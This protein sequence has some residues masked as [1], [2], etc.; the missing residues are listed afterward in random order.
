MH[1]S[2][3]V[4]EGLGAGR[5]DL[6]GALDTGGSAGVRAARARPRERVTELPQRAFRPPRANSGRA[7]AL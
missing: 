7:R 2:D 6:C 3:E 1:R 5:D 4:A